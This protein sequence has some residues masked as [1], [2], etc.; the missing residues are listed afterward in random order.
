[1]QQQLVQEITG[2]VDRTRGMPEPDPVLLEHLGQLETFLDKVKERWRND[3][4]TDNVYFY[5]AAKTAWLILKEMKAV[6]E[7]FKS[8]GDKDTVIKDALDMLPLIDDIIKVTEPH[9]ISEESID[10]AALKGG[11][12]ID[13]V[14]DNDYA[15]VLIR[16]INSP[17]RKFLGATL[18]NPHDDFI[19][20][21]CDPS[22]RDE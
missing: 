5:A 4:H 10:S 19:Y 1:M 7:N 15:D 16:E 3:P 8:A 11:E 12:L 22:M 2:M 20:T 13:I 9:E 21:P 17:N 14:Y 6:F 18:T